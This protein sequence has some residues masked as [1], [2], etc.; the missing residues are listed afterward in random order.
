MD[1][2]A[3]SDLSQKLS[4]DYVAEIS[5]DD[6]SLGKE[7]CR[8]YADVGDYVD[9]VGAFLTGDL[10]GLHDVLT[11]NVETFVDCEYREPIILNSLVLLMFVTDDYHLKELTSKYLRNANVPSITAILDTH[12]A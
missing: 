9:L 6:I 2:H 7:V 12:F 11:L 5:K 1:A 10:L 8:A 4:L 3:L